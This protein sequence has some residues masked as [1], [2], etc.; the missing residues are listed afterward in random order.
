MPAHSHVPSLLSPPIWQRFFQSHD[1]D[2]L[3]LALDE[4]RNYAATGQT[5]PLKRAKGQ[6]VRPTVSVWCVH[7][8]QELMQLEHE[9]KKVRGK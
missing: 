8:M 2:I 7:S 4:S 3:C 1:D 5:A 9:P 6:D